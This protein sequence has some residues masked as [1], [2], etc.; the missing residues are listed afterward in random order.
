MNT[1]GSELAE[2]LCQQI[3]AAH[4][5]RL[6]HNIAIYCRVITPVLAAAT[7]ES[8]R[9]VVRLAQALPGLPS[10][11]EILAVCPPVSIEG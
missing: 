2:H 9:A 3:L 6:P 7:P 4:R 1:C 5:H 10:R 11:A 8:A